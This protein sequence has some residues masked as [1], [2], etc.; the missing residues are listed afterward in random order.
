MHPA[1]PF[2]A[3][4]FSQALVDEWRWNETQTSQADVLN[5]LEHFA[6]RFDLVKDIQFKTWVTDAPIRQ[7]HT[8]MDD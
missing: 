5:Y 1:G 4:T 8:T 3:Y 6:E 2:Y 7:H